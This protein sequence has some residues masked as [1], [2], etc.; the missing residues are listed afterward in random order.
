MCRYVLLLNGRTFL[1][2]TTANI[3]SSL[4]WYDPDRFNG[5]NL[6]PRI[7]GTP[8]GSNTRLHA[9]QRQDTSIVTSLGLAS[10]QQQ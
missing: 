8:A 10:D 6:S 5:Y 9:M 1:N 3:G 4:R 2:G 7:A